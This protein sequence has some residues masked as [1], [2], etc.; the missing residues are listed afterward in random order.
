MSCQKHQ[1]ITEGPAPEIV[2]PIAPE[3]AGAAEQLHRA[4]VEAAAG[5]LVQAVGEPAADQGE[6]GALE[7]E[8]ELGR[9]GDVGDRVGDRDR[10]R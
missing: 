10:R 6:V 9:G 7:P 8:H 1:S 5:G 2:A 4:L 3:V